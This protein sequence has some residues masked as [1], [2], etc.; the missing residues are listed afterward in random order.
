MGGDF[1]SYEQKVRKRF[2]QVKVMRPEATRERSFEVYITAKG[3]KGDPNPS[4]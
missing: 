3:F 2:E 1:K 4:R